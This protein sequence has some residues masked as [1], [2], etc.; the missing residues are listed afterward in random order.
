VPS[1]TRVWEGPVA[2]IVQFLR[3]ADTFS[4]DAIEVFIK[5]YDMALESLNDFGQP[6]VVR[7]V[8]AK[9]IIEAA[10]RGVVD[11]AALCAD[12]LSAFNSDLTR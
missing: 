6:E 3:P 4:P 11:P 8:I 7:E 5:A 2:Q 10:Q 1:G 9:R 12:A